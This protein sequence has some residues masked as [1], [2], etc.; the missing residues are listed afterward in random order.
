MA[1]QAYVKP[2]VRQKVQT[3]EKSGIQK[4]DWR[5]GS[6]EAVKQRIVRQGKQNPA[7]AVDLKI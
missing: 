3:Q 5:R 7:F 1:M 4:H 6:D 2:Q